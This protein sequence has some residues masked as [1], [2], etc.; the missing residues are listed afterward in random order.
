[1]VLRSRF[2]TSPLAP[3]DYELRSMGLSSS[4]SDLL[5]GEKIVFSYPAWN[6]EG[7]KIAFVSGR[8]GNQEIW[9]L[10][11][12]APVDTHGA[13]S[14]PETGVLRQLTHHPAIDT[15][16]TWSPD[17]RFIGF[18]STRS[19]NADIWVMDVTRMATERS[20]EAVMP[21]G[22]NPGYRSSQAS[23]LQ[24]LTHDPA[25]DHYPHWSPDGKRIAF[26]SDRSG[27]QDPW[28]LELDH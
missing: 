4:A 21:R 18:T 26:T 20:R 12:N 3:P 17:G 2:S 13:G 11:I 25:T 28:L 7:N 10:D 14:R 22:S 5:F 16:P 9:V 27:H 15:H 23:R 8:T 6:P 19:G 24:Q 1:M